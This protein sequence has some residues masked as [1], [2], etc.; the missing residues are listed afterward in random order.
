MVM[1]ILLNTPY[2]PSPLMHTQYTL[3][4]FGVDNWGH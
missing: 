1:M 4:P 2:E 3:E